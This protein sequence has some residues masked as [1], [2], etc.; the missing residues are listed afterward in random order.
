MQMLMPD[1]RSPIAER[2]LQLSFRKTSFFS[3]LAIAALVMGFD[4]WLGGFPNRADR[5][6]RTAAVRFEPLSVEPGGFAPLR[7]AGAW[8]VRVADPRFG[9]IS[10]LAV[11]GGR[12]L[13]LS[14][15]GTVFRLP[16]PGAGNS[17][18]VRDLPDGPGSPGFKRNRDSEALALD[19]A[20]RGW[21]VAFENRHQ[22][23]LY[24]LGFRRPL[25]RIE[26]GRRWPPNSG[27]E[28]MLAIRGG[29]LLFAEGGG[30]VLVAGRG[31][32][33]V[34]SLASRY[35][36]LSDAAAMPDGR[37]LLLGR[38]LGM[39]GFDNR[40][41]ALRRRGAGIAVTGFARLPLGRLANAEALA[42]EPLAHGGA[43][44][45]LMTD[46]DFRLGSRTLLVAL[47]LP[48]TP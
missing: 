15:S 36:R 34:R 42:V 46:N 45:W 6:P 3:S 30:E 9:G 2:C 28:A 41:L 47:D 4:A 32:L 25:A 18:D 22:L 11:E 16:R 27:I 14:D 26:L 8:A 40:L 5:P 33:A 21:W 24:D 17:A 29:L 10:G 35:G 37:I 12:L 39:L 13:A 48:A 19:P 31:R 7:L 43:R 38:R 44:L 20:G 1:S 23:W